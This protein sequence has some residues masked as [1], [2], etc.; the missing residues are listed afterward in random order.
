MLP[1]DGDAWSPSWSPDSKTLTFIVGIPDRSAQLWKWRPREEPSPVSEHEVKRVMFGDD[2]PQWLPDSRRVLVAVPR[3]PAPAAAAVEHQSVDVLVNDRA[4]GVN[5]VAGALTPAAASFEL[6]MFDVESGEMRVVELEDDWESHVLAPSGRFVALQSRIQPVGSAV[7]GEYEADVGLLDL[8]NP[9]RVTTLASGLIADSN[10]G[11]HLPA[12]SPDGERVALI[13]PRSIAIHHVSG[14]EIELPS[15][16]PL[17]HAFALW[18]ADGSGVIAMDETGALWLF[19]LDFDAHKLGGRNVKPFGP[20][21]HAVAS[22]RDGALWCFV[23]DAGDRM[24]TQLWAVPL[25]GGTTK[26]VAVDEG[27][28]EL[29]HPGTIWGSLGDASVDLSVVVHTSGG[30]TAPTSY[31]VRHADGAALPLGDLNTAF[32]AADL[33]HET[34]RFANPCGGNALGAHVLTSLGAGPRP[35]VLWI[36]PG[37]LPSRKPATWE[38]WDLFV[39]HGASLVTEG[40]CVIVGDLPSDNYGA[41]PSAESIAAC[42]VAISQAGSDAG[43]CDPDRFALV[44]HSG[45]GGAVALALSATDYFKAG[46]AASAPMNLAS[47]FGALRVVGPGVVDL[48]GAELAG[49][50]AGGPPW[51]PEHRDELSP[52]RRAD[53]I[54]TPMLLVHG[55]E[56]TRVPVQQSD[57]LFVALTELGRDVTYLRYRGED[58][59]RFSIENRAHLEVAAL[60]FLNR[61]L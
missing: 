31:R 59:N 2:A 10:D 25:D 19:P 15:E 20:T 35:A 11:R 12:W 53:Q 39:A 28:A 50:A 47:H 7:D 16:V 36:Y 57:E 40:Y 4:R 13:L 6:G 30:A 61:Y 14:L 26:V 55:T 29:S 43:L 34:L 56:D 33:H 41:P 32:Q 38:T 52:V 44:G 27:R 5:P 37:A 46:I 22:E 21:S 45:G 49:G 48:P 18:R 51:S 23:P 54:K 58:H 8:A 24:T 60:E 42:A 3:Q 1:T 17:W 9:S